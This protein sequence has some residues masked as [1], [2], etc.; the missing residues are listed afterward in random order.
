MRMSPGS[1][2]S[3]GTLGVRASKTPIPAIAR[4]VMMRV[5]PR[6]DKGLIAVY[7][8]KDFQFERIEVFSGL[9]KVVTA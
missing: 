2:P 9:V 4:P 6:L 8:L 1:F 7:A 5:F 3:H